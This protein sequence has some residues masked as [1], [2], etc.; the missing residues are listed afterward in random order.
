MN[1]C[2]SARVNECVT[3]SI[4]AL[5]AE[6]LSLRA[7]IEALS[8]TNSHHSSS[9]D[10]LRLSPFRS[11][12]RQPLTPTRLSVSCED[13]ENVVIHRNPGEKVE[14]SAELVKINRELEDLLDEKE[15]SAL[16]KDKEIFGLKEQLEKHQYEIETLREMDEGRFGHTKILMA[17]LESL[18]RENENL[19]IEV[20]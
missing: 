20:F 10:G 11:P 19:E 17:T 6:V 1:I 7:R 9:L 5:Q 4:T 12:P 13:K 15:T 18:K 3:G 2:N 16:E 8:K 14:H